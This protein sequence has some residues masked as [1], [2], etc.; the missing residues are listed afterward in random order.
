MEKFK[1]VADV[2]QSGKNRAPRKIPS[3]PH[4]FFDA[5]VYNYIAEKIEVAISF[6]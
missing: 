4:L 2:W 5:E 3:I 1:M 6:M